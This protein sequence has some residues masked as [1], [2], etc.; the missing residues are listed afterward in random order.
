[1]EI[2]SP[3][4]LAMTLRK[5]LTMKNKPLMLASLLRFIIA[6]AAVLNL[7]IGLMFFFGPEL[8]ITLWPS[9]L[10]REMMRFTG[11]IVLA[12]GIGAAMIVR[13][14]TWE[15]ARVLVAVALVY[16]VAVFLGLS[17][18]L[19]AAG[20]PPIFWVYLIINT[21]FLFPAAY[22]FWKYEQSSK[23]TY[24]NANYVNAKKEA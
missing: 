11:S 4:R 20:A 2:A 21:L 14:P 16:G 12:N 1:M 8:G 19:L 10:P 17:I 22:F 3:D 9:P 5:E 6:F 7:L 24:L 18:D 23:E 13:K 15:N